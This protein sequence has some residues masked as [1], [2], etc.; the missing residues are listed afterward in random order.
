[1]P[2]PPKVVLIGVAATASAVS[3]RL[4]GLRPDTNA[5]YL[6]GDKVVLRCRI[7]AVQLAAASCCLLAAATGCHLHR[8]GHGYILRGQWSLECGDTGCVSVKGIEGQC[9]NCSERS[10]RPAE[11]AQAEPELLP[12]RTRLKTRLGDRLFHRGEL[13]GQQCPDKEVIASANDSSRLAPPPM[14]PPVL[15][16]KPSVTR[17]L[18][19]SGT[20][21]DVQLP[22]TA[23]SKPESKRPDLVM[24]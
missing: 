16:E 20:T 6:W 2:I 18:A 12:W 14:P 7:R 1:L 10:A 17:K 21:T 15:P 8:T 23:L 5:T 13:S 3:Q 22:K 24:E 19:P 11:Q 9:E 4:V